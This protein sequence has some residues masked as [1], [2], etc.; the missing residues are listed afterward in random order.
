MHKYVMVVA[1]QGSGYMGWQ[2]QSHGPSVCGAL[3]A[4]LATITRQPVKLHGSGRTDAGVHALNQV[5]HVE[6]TH[7]VD[8]RRLRQSLNALAGEG[9]AVK[10]ILPVSRHFHARH[11]ALGKTYRYLVHNRPWPPVFSPTACH[12]VSRPLNMGAMQAAAAY[13]L[14]TH[15]FSSFR[16]AGCVAHSPVRHMRRVSVEKHPDNDTLVL[17]FEGSGF[18]QHMSR[19]LAGTLLEV[20]ME[21][22]EPEDIPAILAARQRERAGITAPAEGLYLARVFYDT[23][24]FPELLALEDLFGPPGAPA[25]PWPPRQPHA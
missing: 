18:L 17:E 25:Q 21:K 14:G 16:A 22:R 2:V 11:S 4:A 3:Q 23:D 7:P 12:W 20:G 1:Y 13:L 9:I 19:I 5:A 6:L 10:R 24:I 8:P 15:D